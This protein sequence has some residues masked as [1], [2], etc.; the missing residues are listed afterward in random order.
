MRYRL[1]N[2]WDLT[3]IRGIPDVVLAR[4]QL[5]R[6]CILEA[7]YEGVELAPEDLTEEIITAL[8][9]QMEE[10]DPQADVRFSVSCP[11]CGCSWQTIFDIVSYLWTEVTVVAQRMLLDVHELARLWMA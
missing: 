8:T 2:S 4:N 10:Q 11:I 3:V 6:Q 9:A 1:P 5:L 7:Q